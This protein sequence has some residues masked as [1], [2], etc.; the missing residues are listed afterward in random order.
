MAD[1]KALSSSFAFLQ[2]SLDLKVS[3]EKC[4]VLK[5]P[6]K[7]TKLIKIM[8]FL[9]LALFMWRRLQR[10]AKLMLY[11]YFT[12]CYI[13]QIKIIERYTGQIQ[14]IKWYISRI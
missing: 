10:K 7:E 14:D 9:L 3:I 6:G 12:S 13:E 5:H 4:S 11:I 8:V 1:D 2:Y